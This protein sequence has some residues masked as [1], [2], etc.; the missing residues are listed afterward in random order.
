MPPTTKDMDTSEERGDRSSSSIDFAGEI[1][2]HELS[3]TCSENEDVEKGKDTVWSE[4][5]D[6]A[7]DGT[8]ATAR[9]DSA[10][11]DTLRTNSME[12]PQA[13]VTVVTDLEP[14]EGN[15]I[16]EKTD[17]FIQSHQVVMFNKTWCLFSVD[18][19]EFLTEQMKVP[20]HSIEVDL[21]PQGKAILKHVQDKTKHKT[22]PVI[23][24]K[25]KFLGGF[26]DVNQLYATGKLQ[27]EYLKGI[28][29]ADQCQEFLVKAKV[30]TKPLFWFP[31][32]VNA[33]VTRVAAG[34][35]AIVALASAVAVHWSDVGRY[36]C[37]ILF[38]DFVLRFL[39]GAQYS[40]VGRA[41]ML[42]VVGLEPKTRTGRPTQF[43]AALGIGFSGIASFCYLF[44]MEGADYLG[45]ILLAM[46]TMAAGTVACFDFCF[47]CMIFKYGIKMGLIP[48]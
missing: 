10:K 9:D 8:M 36:L 38:L 18:A 11:G 35:T 45:T 30:G 42:L 6:I 13:T 25:G 44:K 24:V 34:L 43:A 19:Q 37:Y 26:E 15:T 27:D 20:L 28:S 1:K 21:H 5:G 12:S 39:A 29:Q 14:Y 22:V 2:K 17:S 31:D 46:L 32:S 3:S 33:H 47:G 4:T 16:E 48:K 7:D 41:A 40:P 23:F